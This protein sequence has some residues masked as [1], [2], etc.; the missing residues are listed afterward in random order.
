MKAKI[1]GFC[2]LCKSRCGAVFVTEG[3]RLV[4]QEPDPSHPTGKALCIKGRAA[5][6]IV[7]AEGRALYPMRRT[8]PKGA[9]DPGWIR[10]GWDEALDEVAS[11]L[12]AI[13]T[14]HGA[15]SV[16]F[17]WTTP[18]GTAIAD[19]IHWIERFTNAFGSPNVAYGT[20]NCNWAKDYAHAFTTGQPIGEPDFDET[21][22]VLLWGHNPSATWLDHATGVARARARGAKVIVIDPRRAGFASSADQWLRVRPGTDGVLALAL[23]GEMISNGWFDAEFVRD[24]SNGP[25]LVRQDTGRFLRAKDLIAPPTGSYPDDLVGWSVDNVPVAFDLS[26][27]RWRC[28]SS[29][30]QCDVAPSLDCSVGPVLCDTAFA[31]FRALA[32]QTT[33]ECAEEVCW[34]PAEQIRQTAKLIHD[35]GPLSYYCWSGISEH[36]N[37]TQTDRAIAIVTAL[38]GSLE[39]PGGNR[40]FGRVKGANVTGADFMDAAQSAKCLGR[41]SGSGLG[42]ERDNWITSGQLYDA[43][44]DHTPYPIRALVD[45]GRNF[46]VTHGDGDRGAAALSALEFHVHMD[47]RVTDTARYADIF[48]PVNTPWERDAL[49]IGFDGGPEAQSLVQL[50]EAAIE[51]RGESRSDAEIVFD[52]ACRMDFGELFWNGDIEAGYNAMLAPLCQTAAS[53]RAAGGRMSFPQVTGDR[54]YLDRGFATPTRRLEIYSE[55]LH[56]AGEAP[57]PVWVPPKSHSTDT[58]TYPLVLTS[59]KV[60]QFTHS[61]FRDVPSLRK[62]SPEPVLS[63]SSELGM[64]RGLADGD[65]VVLT[66]PLG[67]VH[68][69]VKFDEALH[70]GVVVV[71]YGWSDG[72]DPQ[73]RININRLIDDGRGDPISGATGLRSARCDIRPA[74]ARAWSGWRRFTIAPSLQESGDIT[75][76]VLRPED[77]EELPRHAG[78][79]FIT[80]RILD[81]DG[82]LARCYSLSGQSAPDGYRISVKN[83]SRGMSGLLHGL[84][85]GQ[86][87]AELLAPSGAFTLDRIGANKVVLVAAGIGITP[88]LSMLHHARDSARPGSYVLLYGARTTEDLA[89]LGELRALAAEIDLELRLFV[90]QGALPSMAERHP[91]EHWQTGR[92]AAT[93]LTERLGPDDEA[94]IC[95]PGTMVTQFTTDLESAGIPSKQIHTEAFGPSASFRD[96]GGPQNITLSRSGRVVGYDPQAGTLLDILE[97]EG[98]N[99]ESGCRSGSCQS[100]EVRLLSGRV[101][102]PTGVKPTNSFCRPCV[103]VPL[104]GIELEI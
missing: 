25:M 52:L 19:N 85:E 90:S 87:Q 29:L 4:A 20:E 56:D 74:I 95:G 5:P 60:V 30:L 24:W 33:A 22:C 32:A 93:D 80:L 75:S 64:M 62:R 71:P 78:G 23:A 79:Q 39:A 88:L 61:A 50:R 48:L 42:P 73:H 72:L 6:E 51:S 92:I 98:I 67:E 81:G 69:A 11:R 35:S 40:R 8:A 59:A 10:I 7:Y 96:R 34:V 49:R 2:A 86:T 103:C 38:T 77:E 27:G 46:L 57:L 53:L 63:I 16:A 3:G 26:E 28:A 66:T 82:T 41:I 43:A 44:L 17:G 14:A 91:G 104:E 12:G 55:Q 18:S 58:N 94:M 101:A 84:T 13:R 47:V 31:L 100:C 15:E 89:F 76:F 68:L 45:F 83:T 65:D 9:A 36:T 54:P 21:G 37:S 1:Q 97:K 99:I 102:H 70:P